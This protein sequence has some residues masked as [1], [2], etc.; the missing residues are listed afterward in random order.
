MIFNMNMTASNPVEQWALRLHVVLGLV[1]L[2]VAPAAMVVTKGGWWHRLWGRI[3]V[4]SMVVVLAAAVPLSYF[5]ND[6]FLFCMSIVVSYLTLSGYRI[7]VR[8]RRNYRAAVIDWAGALGAAAAGVVAVRVAIRGDGSDRGV[9]MVVFAALFW[10][11]AWTD[12]RGFIRPPQEKREWWFIHMSRMLGAYLGALTAISVVQMGWLPT[13]VRWFWP[14]ALGV[15]GIM[16][17]MRYYR[18]KFARAERRSAIPITPGQIAS[19]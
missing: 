17:W 8:K 11:L 3:F 10:L 9:V 12:I 13:P 2:L 7:H 14:T 6:P 5:A 4:G 15:P 16:L 1:A 19:G 18:H